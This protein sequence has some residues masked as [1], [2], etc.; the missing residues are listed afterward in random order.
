MGI[1]ILLGVE[2]WNSESELWVYERD[3]EQLGDRDYGVFESLVGTR[4]LEGR[5]ANLDG[6]NLPPIHFVDE[7]F[8]DKEGLFRVAGQVN[9]DELVH[10][11]K[12]NNLDILDDEDDNYGEYDF[13]LKKRFKMILVWPVC[14]Y[15]RSIDIPLNKARL[16]FGF[17]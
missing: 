2:V 15:L 17:Y 11:I 1:D 12:H 7:P 4:F 16:L 8:P 6:K 13:S 3:F 9:V 5:D 14:Q 10:W